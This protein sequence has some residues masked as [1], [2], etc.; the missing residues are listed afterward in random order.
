L[1]TLLSVPLE[2]HSF[3]VLPLFLNIFC[4]QSGR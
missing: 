1:V 2:N 3:G 4:S